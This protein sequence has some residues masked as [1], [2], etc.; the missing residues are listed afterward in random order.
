MDL[1]AEQSEPVKNGLPH[2]WDLVVQDM[3][4]RNEHGYQHYKTY[5]QPF[6]GRDALIDL[7][8][9][10]LDAVVYLRQAI[11]ERDNK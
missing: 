10:L 8:Q 5:L 1:N 4:Q 6:N 9:E 7:Y 11:F 3:E 2:V